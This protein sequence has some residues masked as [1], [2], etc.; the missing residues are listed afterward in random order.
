VGGKI[1]E[2][3]FDIETLPS[4]SV[5]TGECEPVPGL[6]AA[7][8]DPSDTLHRMRFAPLTARTLAV[9]MLNPQTHRGKVWYEHPQGV[10]SHTE[11]GLVEVIPATEEVMLGE[12]W[13]AVTRFERLITFNGRLFDSPFLMLRSALLGIGPSRNL[14][15]YRFSAKEHCDLLDQLSFYGA[16]RRFTLESYCRGFRIAAPGGDGG[17]PDVSLLLEQGRYR[18]IADLAAWTV[19]ATAELYRRWERMLSFTAGDH[20]AR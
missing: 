17:R 15:P 16:T 18:E 4:P 1:S 14:M 11:D 10:P 5:V 20:S 7:G 9:A 8:E 13:R 12:F 2:V 6:P 3:V 19:T